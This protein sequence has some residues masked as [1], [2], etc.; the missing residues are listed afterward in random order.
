MSCGEL[1][2]IGRNE[3][4]ASNS[5]CGIFLN[6]ADKNCECGGPPIAPVGVLNENPACDICID[7]R[8]V[9]ELKVE[10]LVNTGIAGEMPC[11]FL[12]ETAAN[13]FMPAHIC[14]II[15]KNVADFCCTIPAFDP[16]NLVGDDEG[17]GGG[18]D[19]IGNPDPPQQTE[20][21]SPCANLHAT[22]GIGTPC[23]AAYTCKLRVI[24]EQPSCSVQSE[25]KRE[26]IAGS[27]GRGGAAGRAKY[28]T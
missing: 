10:E 15:Q 19:N 6:H 17:E 21:P 9:P 3:L 12:Y 26:S 5:V 28:G 16:D 25:R 18:G 27:D 24:G 11:G 14:P 4:L 23:C 2:D 20:P 7:G 8:S 13:G 1:E 22:C